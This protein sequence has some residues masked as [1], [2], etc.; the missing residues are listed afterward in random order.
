MSSISLNDKFRRLNSVN[1][2]IMAKMSL[3]NRLSPR[4]SSR[5]AVAR[6][7][8]GGG[9][10]CAL[11]GIVGDKLLALLIG[12]GDGSGEASGEE[13][14]GIYGAGNVSSKLLDALIVTKL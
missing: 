1:L 2:E 9:L 3:V 5:R 6:G 14:M 10:G 12:A 11:T 4:N 8:V 13:G 7:G